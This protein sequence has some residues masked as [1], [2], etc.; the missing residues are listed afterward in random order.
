VHL[1]FAWVS[2]LVRDIEGRSQPKGLENRMPRK[3]FRPK[4]EEVA[5]DWRRLQRERLHGLYCSVS[6]FL[7][8]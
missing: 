3:T 8:W 5:G 7:N 1:S 6:A 4:R 2:N